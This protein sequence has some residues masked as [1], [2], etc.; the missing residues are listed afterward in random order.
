M[1]RILITGASGFVGK[2]LCRAL[3]EQGHAVRAAVRNNWGQSRMAL[4]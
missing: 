4:T 1:I 2:P 3:F